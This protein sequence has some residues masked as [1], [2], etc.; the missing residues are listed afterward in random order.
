[1]LGGCATQPLPG[2]GEDV[3][4]DGLQHV[5]LAMRRHAVPGRRQTLEGGRQSADP[6]CDGRLCTRGTGGIGAYDDP[7]RLRQ[8][9]LRVEEDGKQRFKPVSWDEALDFIA[10]RMSAIGERHGKDR[11]ALFSHGDGGKHFQR[12]LQAFGSYAYAHPSFAQCRG[13]RA[14]AFG[15]TYGEGVGSPDRTDMAN[16]RCIVLIGSHI[17][18]NLHNSQ[19][20]TL[21]QALDK[22]ATV[23]TVDPRFSV[24]A[25]KSQHWLPIKPGTDIALLLAWINVLINEGL[26]DRDYVARYRSGFDKLVA[27]VQPY[28]PE[29]AYLETGIEPAVI[30]ETARAMAANAPATLVHPTPPGRRRHPPGILNARRHPAL[31][32]HRDPQWFAA[33][34]VGRPGGFYKQE[35]VKLP[36]FPGG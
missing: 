21:T 18:E 17:G 11:L 36:P 9:L 34:F 5:F 16:S 19:V 4:A 12:V 15:L 31:P 8:P 25:S 28:N 2:T 22:G 10:A 24:A 20:Q 6:H 26:Y 27:H 3:D 1:M 32:G 7:D 14:T 13:P 23:I 29:W 35:N 30:R 33:R